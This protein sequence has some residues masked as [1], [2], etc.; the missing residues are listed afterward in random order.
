MRNRFFFSRTTGMLAAVGLSLLGAGKASAGF[1]NVVPP[2]KTEQTHE[3][4]LEHVY[5]GN[6]TASGKDYSNG[7]ITALRID[8]TLAGGSLNSVTGG[9]GS[10]SDQVWSGGVISATAKARFAK[11]SQAFGYLAGSTGSTFSS[12]FNVSG[13][14]FDAAGSATVD[15]SGK[16]FRW[17]RDGES[18]LRSSQNADN[19]DGLD[20]LV[21]YKITGAKDNRSTWMLMWEDRAGA[22][23]DRDF[24]DLAIEVK[25]SGGT[26]PPVTSIPL[27]PAVWSAL[28][29]MAF[30]MIG[31]AKRLK[32]ML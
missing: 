24:N 27:P 6:F 17:A 11:F 10:A 21:T 26:P 29:M 9:P 5:G 30:G 18:G 4:V 2:S 7:S 14:G 12:L 28:G 8:D 20:H 13:S 23:A 22:G 32:A 1:T 25:A 3:Q 19:S 16:T 15:L 31:G